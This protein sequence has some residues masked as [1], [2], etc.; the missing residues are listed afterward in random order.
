M[1]LTDR[2][3]TDNETYASVESGKRREVV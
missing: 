1:A 2:L 3:L